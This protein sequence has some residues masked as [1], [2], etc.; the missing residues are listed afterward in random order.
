[1]SSHQD[2]L[3]PTPFDV[4]KP[5]PTEAGETPTKGHQGTPAWVL[6]AL[7]GL[8]LLAAMVIFWLPERVADTPPP[9]DAPAEQA[10]GTDATA[11]A[12]PAAKPKPAGEEASPWSD[13]QLAKLRK[14]AQDVLQELL[15]LQFALEERGVQQWAAEEFS[16]AGEIAA[17]GDELYKTREYEAAKARYQ[18]SL[19]AFQALQD[20]IPQRLQ[21]Q[22]DRTLQG[23]EELDIAT[24]TAAL[25]AATL[26]DPTAPQ[27]GDLDQRLQTLPELVSLLEQAVAAEQAGDLAGAETLLGNAAKLDPAHQRVAAELQRVAAAHLEQRFNDAMS[28][29]YIALDES[30][31]NNARTAFRAA[32]KLQPG[33]AEAA[34]ALQEVDAAETAYRLAALK[35]QGE[36]HE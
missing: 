23:I 2:P 34:S 20:S 30:R 18:E 33:S 29:G 1:M 16:A 11:A 10:S 19:A 4:A 25:D 26:I 35:R 3:E 24:A 14:E 5:A 12:P 6:P 28:D 32:A 36:Q 13:A 21:A 22:L 9:T 15:D 27:L 7:G 31:F 8:L 17:A